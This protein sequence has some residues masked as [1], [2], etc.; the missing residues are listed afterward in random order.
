[1]KRI[2]FLQYQ[3]SQGVNVLVTRCGLIVD[4]FE[5]WLADGIVTDPNQ[6]KGCLE[7]ACSCVCGKMTITDACRQVSAFCLV[8]QKG[9]EKRDVLT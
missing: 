8:E 9:A 5:S 2:P 3:C 4:E 7:V 6:D 1:M